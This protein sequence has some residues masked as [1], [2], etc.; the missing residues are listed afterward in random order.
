MKTELRLKF[1]MKMSLRWGTSKAHLKKKKN[2][3]P[4]F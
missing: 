3:V 1:V 2:V 4:N